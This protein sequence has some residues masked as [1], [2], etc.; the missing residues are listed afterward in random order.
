MY[1]FVCVGPGR[2]EVSSDRCA[3]L[4]SDAVTVLVGE[5]FQSLSDGGLLVKH[6]TTGEPV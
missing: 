6:E 3:D 4:G 1:A 2:G 5:P